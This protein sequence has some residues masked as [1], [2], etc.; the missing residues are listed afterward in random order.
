MF[1]NKRE[2]GVQTCS[3]ETLSLG[4]ITLYLLRFPHWVSGAG[5]GFTMYRFLE[6]GKL[7]LREFG[8]FLC[9]R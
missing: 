6:G 9:S 4:L 1:P 5:A 3:L 7:P 8:T 2:S